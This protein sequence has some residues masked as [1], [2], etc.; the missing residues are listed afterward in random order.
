MS[1]K[2]PLPGLR[3]CPRLQRCAFLTLEIL[4]SHGGPVSIFSQNPES[5]GGRSAF[6][7]I[8][9]A[10]RRQ[11]LFLTCRRFSELENGR[12]KR[13]RTANLSLNPISP[14][15]MPC[16]NTALEIGVV[17]SLQGGRCD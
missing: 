11:R 17:L 1:S 7:K 4:G 3:I 6:A 13:T 2:S 10:P 5:S 14:A 8:V 9:R 12:S 16:C 15:A